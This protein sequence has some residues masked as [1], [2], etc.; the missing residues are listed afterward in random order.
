MKLH[1]VYTSWPMSTEPGAGP[2]IAG[3]RANGVQAATRRAWPG[4]IPQPSREPSRVRSPTARADER[5]GLRVV[6]EGFARQ[7]DE[8]SA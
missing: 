5:E 7:L 6:V 2:L 3:M 4:G 1:D 8:Y